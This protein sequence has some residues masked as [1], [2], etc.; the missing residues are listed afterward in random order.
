MTVTLFEAASAVTERPSYRVLWGWEH[1]KLE[2]HLLRLD[3][4]DRYRRFGAHLSD[5]GIRGRAR[6]MHRRGTVILV[7]LVDGAVRGTVEV[8]FSSTG[9]ER[10]AEIALTVE[11]AYRGRGIGGRLFAAGRMAAVN[12]GATELVLSTQL[13]NRAMRSIARRHRMRWQSDGNELQAT[14][15]LP[16]C[17]ARDWLQEAGFHGRAFLAQRV[18]FAGIRQA[19]SALQARPRVAL[20]PLRRARHRLASAAMG[21][22][23]AAA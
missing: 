1:D 13:D 8:D 19:A 21:K 18:S 6:R 5:A 3:Q 9:V 12:R 2:A 17:A 16:R 23:A 14:L 11:R 10:P 15:S 20:A 4:E 7:A 22:P